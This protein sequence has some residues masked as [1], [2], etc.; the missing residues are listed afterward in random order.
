MAVERLAL[1]HLECA[2][3]C[4]RCDDLNCAFFGTQRHTAPAKAAFLSID[5]N[6]R[7]PR[8]RIRGQQVAHTNVDAD[9][10]PGAEIFVEV[11]R[12]PRHSISPL[13]SR[14]AKDGTPFRLSRSSQTQRQ[15][16]QPLQ[17]VTR[18]SVLSRK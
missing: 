9:I 7:L 3:H 13:G 2:S 15:G 16:Q 5:L 14:V 10:T 12:F 1:S 6:R 4:K 17:V 8:F 11:N 18:P